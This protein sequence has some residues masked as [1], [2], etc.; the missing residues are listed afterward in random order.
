VRGSARVTIEGTSVP[1][2]RGS[3]G[4]RFRRRSGQGARVVQETIRAEQSC[5][6]RLPLE[7]VPGEG[8]RDSWV[9]LRGRGRSHVPPGCTFRDSLLKWRGASGLAGQ[10]VWARNLNPEQDATTDAVPSGPTK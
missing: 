7:G 5:D 10:A 8:D 9:P 6:R 2:C 1:A 3:A 4:E